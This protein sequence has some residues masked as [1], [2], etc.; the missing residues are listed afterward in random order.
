MGSELNLVADLAVILI[1]AG[2]EHILGWYIARAETSASWQALLSRIAPPDMVVTDGGTGFSSAVRRVWPRTRVQ[3][4]LYH[5]FSQVRRYTTSRPNL[6]AGVEL[7][8][9]AKDL[10]H[11]HTLHEASEWTQRYLEWAGFWADFLEERS[12]IDGRRV[13]THERLRAARASISTLVNKD[14]LFTYL[15]PGVCLGEE[16][17]A[18]NNRIE[19]VNGQLREVMRN[20]RGMGLMHRIKAV[21][22][23]CYMHTECP[24]AFSEILNTMPTDEDIELL[25]RE[26]AV[27]PDEL[28]RPARWGS[29]LVW[30][31][32][33]TSTPY[34]GINN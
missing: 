22:W 14:L 34:G 24:A 25:R 3:R 20:H 6:Q 28:G 29:G 4:C 12:I 18:T 23:W 9:I 33:H 5:V 19:R 31:E 11:V 16:L 17:P 10:L 27:R 30:N 21:Y 8:A 15:D 26:Y 2:E 32:L 7:Y 13:Y 1:A